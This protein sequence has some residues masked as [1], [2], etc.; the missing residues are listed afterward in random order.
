MLR[1]SRDRATLPNLVAGFLDLM[2]LR[3]AEAVMLPPVTFFLSRRQ[4]QYR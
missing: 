2:F 3:P 1:A 4:L